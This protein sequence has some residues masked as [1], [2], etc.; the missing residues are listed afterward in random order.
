MGKKLSTEEFIERSKKFHGDKYDYSISNYTGRK[1]MIDIICPVHGIISQPAGSHM[2][3]HG[4]A[5]C[6]GFL[7][8]TEQIVEEA[9]RVHGDK[10]DYSIS[11]YIG[12]LKPFSYICPIHGKQTQN[13]ADHLAGKGCGSCRGTKKKTQEQF[14]AEAY[15]VHGDKYDYSICEYI[16]I[17]TEV[18]ILCPEHGEFSQIAYNHLKGYGCIDCGRKVHEGENSHFYIDGR[19]EHNKVERRSYKHK[20]WSD[21]IKRDKTNCDCCGIYFSKD[22]VAHAHHLNSWGAYPEQRLDISNGIT[23]CEIC[24]VDFHSKYGYWNNT[25]EQYYQFKELMEMDYGK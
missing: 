25:K 22:I 3:G 19:S 20:K 21:D 11:E 6:A 24:H 18:K 8:T 23:L 10:Y 1:N 7:K 12:Q 4:C 14:I 16:N 17:D 9:I 13:T 15:A 2:T 5:R